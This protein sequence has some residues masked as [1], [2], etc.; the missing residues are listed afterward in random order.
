L[1]KTAGLPDKMVSP[2]VTWLFFIFVAF[3][4]D[5]FFISPGRYN[6]IE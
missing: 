1:Q 4:K 5:A 2:V 3:L 6:D